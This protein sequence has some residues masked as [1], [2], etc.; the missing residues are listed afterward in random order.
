MTAAISAGSPGATGTG[1]CHQPMT[2]VTRK[3]LR[4]IYSSGSTARTSHPAPG[5]ARSP[6]RPRAAPPR[7][8]RRRRRR[9]R[10]RERRAGRDACADP[11]RAG[12][13][14]GP[15][16]R[17]RSPN[18]IRTA[19]G[20]PPPAGGR[21]AGGTVRSAAAT[22]SCPASPVL[23][24]D[25]PGS[26]ERAGLDQLRA[27]AGSVGPVPK[28]GQS[29]AIPHAP[30]AG[31]RAWQTR[32][33]CQIS[34]CDSIVH[35]DFGNR[36]PDLLL[37]LDRVILGGPAEPARQPGEMGVHRDPGHAEG[38]AEHD[39]RRLAARRPAA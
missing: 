12:S 9:S 6:R 19:A 3:S 35:S 7:P 17:Y 10:R 31:L 36:A 39:V 1:V 25:R 34:R 32:R 23:R 2:G 28:D 33:P 11:P 14:A 29:A 8:D 37:D 30:Q 18:R 5:Q 38:V 4:Q 27:V 16:R 24:R 13:A 26:R 21:S 15:A 22:V 20:L